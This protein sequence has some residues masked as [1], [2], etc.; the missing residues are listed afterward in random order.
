MVQDCLNTVLAS[1]HMGVVEIDIRRHP[2]RVVLRL[3]D[4]WVVAP[5]GKPRPIQKGHHPV[6][7]A[8]EHEVAPTAALHPGSLGMEAL[9]DVPV[10]IPEAEEAAVWS[11][12]ELQQDIYQGPAFC[13][14]DGTT[15]GTA[16]LRGVPVVLVGIVAGCGTGDYGRLHQGVEDFP[17]L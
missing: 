9:V 8:P 2:A 4:V 16:S 13:F 1:S 5:E 3:Q 15:L 6:Q 14:G 17:V 10:A 11:P 7:P 12:G